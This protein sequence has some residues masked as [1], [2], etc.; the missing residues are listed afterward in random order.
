MSRSFAVAA[1]SFAFWPVAVRADTPPPL[2]H[3]VYSF[4]YESR[5]HGTVPHDPG[6]SGAGSYNAKVDDKGTITV[7]VLR[8]APDR[9][10]TVVVS[11]QGIYTRRAAPATCAVYGN[12]T[13]FCDPSKTVNI[14]EYTLLRFLGVNFVDP[15]TIDAK[16]HWSIS[17]SKGATNLSADY[18]IESI[19]DGAMTIQESRYAKD[20]T[21]S[22]ETKIEYDFKR[23]LPTA[24]DEYTTEDQH[25]GLISGISRTTYQTTLTLVSDS[26]A[27]Q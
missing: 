8:E 6:T 14:E 27:K 26:M 24:I 1:L 21:F 18:T 20:T 2:R 13:V 17:Q 5:L 10:L 4:T 19:S 22:Y 9:G 7:D 12:T 16:N 15:K 23:L 11:E 3:L 25:A